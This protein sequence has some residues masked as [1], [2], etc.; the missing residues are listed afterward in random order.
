[1]FYITNGI[2]L[3]IKAKTYLFIYC[4]CLF[5]GFDSR[6]KCW[7][8]KETLS[9]KSHFFVIEFQLDML[10]QCE[11]IKYKIIIK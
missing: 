11:Q 9:G 6:K 2:Y 5:Q 3:K 10:G 8:I 1:M 7:N 4:K